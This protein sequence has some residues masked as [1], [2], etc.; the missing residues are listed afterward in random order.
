MT[1]DSRTKNRAGAMIM[2]S[3]QK[4]DRLHDK[5]DRRT[6]KGKNDRVM[7]NYTFAKN[8]ERVWSF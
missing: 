2:R 6:K 8:G 3:L 7:S 4:I 5:I 1:K